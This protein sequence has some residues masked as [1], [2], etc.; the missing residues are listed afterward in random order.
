MKLNFIYDTRAVD[1]D[2]L[3]FTLLRHLS[4][5]IVS[6]HI[7]TVAVDVA[8]AYTEH[9]HFSILLYSTIQFSVA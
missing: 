4:Q 5:C 7:I 9:R 1:E 8:V 3:H 6:H 2:H